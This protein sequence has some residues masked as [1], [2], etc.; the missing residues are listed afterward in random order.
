MPPNTQ[1]PPHTPEGFTSESE[2][3]SANPLEQ[4]RSISDTALAIAAGNWKPALD[5]CCPHPARIRD[6]LLGGENSYEI[7]RAWCTEQLRI[8]PSLRR[9]CRDERGFLLRAV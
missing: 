4:H 8:M 2:S 1:L 5:L 3:A 9:I 7:D 6:F